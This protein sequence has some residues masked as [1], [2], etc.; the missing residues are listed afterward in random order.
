MGLP[1]PNCPPQTRLK[2]HSHRRQE[3]PHLMP[4]GPAHRF[5]ERAPYLIR[6]HQAKPLLSAVGRG[7]SSS[8]RAGAHEQSASLGTLA[9]RPL[10]GSLADAS[11]KF[12]PRFLRFR[13]PTQDGTSPP[14]QRDF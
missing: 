6:K 11:C 9:R 7:R 10:P 5:P 3:A 2:G 12:L 13:P 1:S 8:L 14:P 4:A